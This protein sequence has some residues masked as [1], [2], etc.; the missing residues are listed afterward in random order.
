MLLASQ[1]STDI[2]GDRVGGL[3]YAGFNGAKRGG[4]QMIIDCDRCVIRLSGRTHECQDCLVT[5]LLSPPALNRAEERAVAVLS[6]SGLVPPLR[7]KVV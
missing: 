2:C 6:A 3:T 7:L 1:S 4:I 5:F